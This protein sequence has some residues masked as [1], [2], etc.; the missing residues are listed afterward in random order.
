MPVAKENQSEQSKRFI[1]A[2]RELGCDEDPEAF[3][4]KLKKLASAPPPESVA[5]RKSKKSAK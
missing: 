1:E 2:A 4:D 3:K 5:T